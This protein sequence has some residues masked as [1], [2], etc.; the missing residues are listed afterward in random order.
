LSNCKDVNGDSIVL[1]KLF[2]GCEKDWKKRGGSELWK[3]RQFEQKEYILM[4]LPEAGM[5]STVVWRGGE[6]DVKS[7]ATA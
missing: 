1:Q 7:L 3:K 2:P 5:G 6:S 4:F